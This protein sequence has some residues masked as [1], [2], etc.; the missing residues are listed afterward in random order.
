MC[1]LTNWNFLLLCIIVYPT[2]QKFVDQYNSF[3][4]Y[5]L[6][7]SNKCWCFLYNS[8]A[9]VATPEVIVFGWTFF[10]TQTVLLTPT[11]HI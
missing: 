3:L 5:S 1:A 7:Y 2:V 8:V 6:S 10:R 11:L 4:I 9:T